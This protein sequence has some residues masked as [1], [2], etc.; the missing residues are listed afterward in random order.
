MAEAVSGWSRPYHAVQQIM[1]DIRMRLA[2][3]PTI[4]FERLTIQPIRVGEMTRILMG[5]GQLGNRERDLDRHV[6][7][8][9]TAAERCS[10]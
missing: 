5:V 9:L 6:P 7:D 4:K 10:I 1:G 3:Y 2:E 8:L